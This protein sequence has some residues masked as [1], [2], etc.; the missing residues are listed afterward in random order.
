MSNPFSRTTINSQHEA[1]SDVPVSAA[2]LHP[3]LLFVC[4][5]VTISLEP[6][7]ICAYNLSFPLSLDYCVP[8]APTVVYHIDMRIPALPWGGM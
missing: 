6:S 8:V 7:N 1:Y 2:H 5:V 4:P 3:S